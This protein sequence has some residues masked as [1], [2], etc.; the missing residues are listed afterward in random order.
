M[1]KYKKAI[2]IA[3]ALLCFN[4]SGYS[5]RITLNIRNI[6]V[7]QAMNR[8]TQASGYSFIFS[9]EDINAKKRISISAT[10]AD[11]H[12]VVR[13]ILRGQQ[14]INYEIQGKNII[15]RKG[16]Q[17][18]SSTPESKNTNAHPNT[19]NKIQVSGEIVDSKGEAVIGASIKLR[20]EQSGTL[21]DFNG[22][23]SLSAGSSDVLIIS[24]IG[25]DT[26]EIKV[27]KEHLHIILREKSKSLDEVVV[28]GYATQKKVNLTGAVSAVTSDDLAGKPVMSTA[29]ALAGLAPGISIVQNSGRPGAGASLKIR[30]TGT[31][32]SAGN[33][34]L[35]LIDG[36]S[37]SIDDVDPN[38]IQSIS[39][40][41][42]AASA[43]IYG[44]RAANGVIL[45]ETKNGSQGKTTITYNNSFGWQRPT[46]LPDFLP[47]WEYA[48][49]YNIAMR[50]MGKNEVYST[51]DIEKYK[52]GSDPDNYPNVNHLKWLLGTGSGFQQQHNLAIRGGNS[53]IN[54]NLSLGYRKQD[55]IT[56]R[57]SNKRL[58]ALL[59]L[60]AEINKNLTFNLHAN[61][62]SNIYNAPNEPRGLDGM[63][64]FAVRERPNIAG[65]RTDGSYGYQDDASPEA[66]LASESFV[67]NLSRHISVS[68]QL[69][70]KLPIK[71]LSLSGKG[72]I[73]YWT[74]FDR[75][76]VAQTYFDENKTKGP[77]SLS[78]GSGDNYTTTLEAIATYEFK[79]KQ[80]YFKLLAGTSAE[81]TVKQGLSGSRNTFPNN[82]LYELGAG[83]KSTADNGSSTSESALLSYFGRLNYSFDDRYLLEA[84]LR[85]DGSS[86]FA[87]K[88][89]WGL[90]PSASVGW[91][92][93]EEKFWKS[94]SVSN[95]INNLKLRVSYGVLGNQ[96][97]GD[98]P[99]QQVYN[100]GTDY[101]LGT[102]PTLQQGV[103]VGTYNNS[104]ITWEK[105]AITN[106][107]LDFG[108]LNN[109]LSGSI[110]YFYKK[111]SDILAS[112]ELAGTMG[113]NVGQSNVGTVSNK[114]IEVNLTYNGKFGKNFNF[115]ISPNFTF[116]KN[117]VEKLAD[118]KTEE[119]NSGRIV[120]QPIGIIYGYESDGL[121]VDQA[122][123][124]AAPEQLVQKSDLKPG[125]VRY[126]DISGPDGVPDGKV[127]SQYDR[128]VL[129]STTPK[130][131]YGMTLSASYQGFDFSVLLQG[132][133]GYN[134]LIGSYMAYAFYND[135]QI[136]RWQAEG[137][138]TTEN[139]DKWAEY[140]LLETA[141]MS[142]SN[143]Q[144]SDY[145][146][147]NATFLR[148]KNVQFG[149]TFPRNLIQKL[150]IQRLRIYFS[151]Q[152]L[153]S[154][155]SFY[156][157]WDP[158]NE[159]GTGDNP[160]Y[161][162]INRV[163][164]FGLNL[165]F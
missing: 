146:L 75:S 124:N 161:Y 150:G 108:I 58:T 25:Y 71:G 128:K 98:Y 133:G 33:D 159:I 101:P 118:G 2:F 12:T 96:N 131:Y 90:F 126:K 89:R 93:S 102:T 60:S 155:N 59:S 110:E 24:Y 20:G 92:I 66:W 91:R 49:Y 82:Y 165:T 55:G 31:Y 40:L 30:G 100:L 111:T 156:Q 164:S 107:G 87:P 4:L 61:A 123:I 80:H 3:S 95:V 15:I 53:K 119:I 84:V 45:I 78:V 151:G 139:P 135:G 88:H 63:I 19:V 127:D 54:Y 158:E 56:E 72:G 10:N 6:T 29:Q 23:F 74:N 5:Q 120:G 81:S 51:E 52:D 99:Y 32:S 37:G 129:G 153:H 14:G 113:L 70:W 163:L 162:P 85:Y 109:R 106:V 38:D 76:F 69:V 144:T 97:I 160:S 94:S 39:F 73:N 137:A 50:N 22:R 143:F 1:K 28:V 26:Q 9:N 11:I 115:S 43:A 86:H 134:R 27:T 142:N 77:A 152:N 147:R 148:I 112:M 83:S 18:K 17:R 136:Q 116:V 79:I 8:L 57:T 44:N 138:F 105:T 104:D 103:S 21:T 13:Q 140:P 34:P 46:E 65:K 117:K 64:G 114:G 67:K 122:E 7:T 157:G 41:K 154:F 47:S 16:K 125:Y 68:G 145:W 130:F 62:Y 132:L 48:T 149:Y 35:V 36:L 42:D 121:F 141:N